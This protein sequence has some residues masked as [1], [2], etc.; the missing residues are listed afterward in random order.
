VISP[1]EIRLKAERQYLAFLQSWARGEAFVPLSW[2]AGRPAADFGSLRAQVHLLQSGERTAQSAGYRIEWQVQQTRALSTQTLPVRVWLDTPEDL[3][4]LIE[5][6]DEFARF[7]QD[8][9]LIRA[10]LPQLE[11]WVGRFPRKILEQHASWPGLLAVCGYFL[12]HPRPALY[13]RELPINVHTKFIEQHQGIV[14]ELLEQLL[15]AEFIIADAPTFQQRFG[16]REEEPMVQLRFL[17]DQL[18]QRYG[19][20]LSELCA[21]CSQLAGLDFSDQICLITENKMTFL[22]LPSLPNAF[23]ILGGGFKVSSL[24][25]ISWL[26]S[27]P[28]IYWGDLD[29]Q[30]FQILSQLRS[31]FPHVISLM[32]D[33]ETCTAFAEF[34]VVGTPCRVRN[35]PYLTEEEHKLFIQLAETEQRLEQERISYPYAL[36]QINACLRTLH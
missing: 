30:G 2:P 13:L 23:A 5:K 21:P 9:A 26:H 4:H 20:P 7:S 12:A 28:I 17:D 16:L 27:C 18:Q 3:L 6:E 8:A 35:L 15:P 31:I 14:R 29:A 10:Q 19:L 33:Q 24:A 25:P 11:D 1:A 36:Q 34:C 32:M 22:T